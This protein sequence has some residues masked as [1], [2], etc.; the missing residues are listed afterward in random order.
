MKVELFD[1][2][3]KRDD[4]IKWSQKMTPNERLLLCL[5]LIDLSIAL[6]P[7]KTIVTHS[8]DPIKWIQLRMKDAK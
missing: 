4:Q 3:N 6:A 2:K 7:N 1:I 8:D 5:D